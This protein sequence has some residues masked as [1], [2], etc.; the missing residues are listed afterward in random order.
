MAF[1][2]HGT[3]AGVEASAHWDGHSYA[4]KNV[5]DLYRRYL[6]MNKGRFIGFMPDAGTTED[7]DKSAP[8]AYAAWMAVFDTVTGRSGEFPWEQ[9][10]PGEV[11]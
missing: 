6:S 10:E 7:H 2:I 4:K 11:Y 9:H 3:I 1:T 8:A 5:L